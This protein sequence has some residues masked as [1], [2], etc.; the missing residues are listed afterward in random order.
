[1]AGREAAARLALAAA[2]AAGVSY[3]AADH[4]PLT[5]AA[6]LTWKGAG[7]GLLTVYAAL[8]ARSLDGWLLCAVMGFGAAGDVLLGA[9]S[10]TV[11]GVAFFAGHLIAIALYLK[12]GRPGRSW[13]RWVLGAL[14]VLEAA[15]LA[16]LLPTDRS[17]TA[18]IALYAGVGAAAA[19]CAWLSRF[20]RMWVGLGAMMFL[21]SDELI[22]ARM[23]TLA[24]APWVGFAIWALYFGGQAL[25]CVGVTRS[26]A[27][28]PI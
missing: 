13:G 23:G 4:L 1:M 15:N 14:F 22:F 3:L 19:V 28:T 9:V 16:Y 25:V 18:G 2:I 11:G 17:G 6:S 12:N 5:Q 21:V 10:L 26:L 20:P 8:R 24:G 7:V 27:E